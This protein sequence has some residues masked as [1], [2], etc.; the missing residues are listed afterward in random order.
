MGALMGHLDAYKKVIEQ[1]MT[2]SGRYA[3][4]LA[5]EKDVIL[6]W[7]LSCDKAGHREAFEAAVLAKQPGTV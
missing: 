5:F 7:P 1:S 3:T 2:G 4:V 6:I